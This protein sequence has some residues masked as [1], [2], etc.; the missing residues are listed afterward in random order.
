MRARDTKRSAHLHM[1]SLYRFRHSDCRH[2]YDLRFKHF[3]SPSTANKED[4]T[5]HIEDTV[6]YSSFGNGVAVM[7]L[8]R[9]MA[10]SD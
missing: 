9:Q 7:P 4:S 5:V 1:L 2:G 8:I 3:I 10:T 6:A